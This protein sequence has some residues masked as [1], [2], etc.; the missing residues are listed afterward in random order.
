MLA[1]EWDPNRRVR[2]NRS[3][4]RGM[5]FDLGPHPADP[6][7]TAPRAVVDGALPDEKSSTFQQQQV[8]GHEI[9]V[10]EGS[11]GHVALFL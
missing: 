6:H 9:A 5:S 4:S 3:N 11:G 2:S 8:P 10:Y 1:Y 7:S